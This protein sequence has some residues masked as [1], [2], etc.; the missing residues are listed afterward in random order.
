MG[1]VLASLIG[2][3][4]AAATNGLAAGCGS[5][6]SAP[7]VWYDGPQRVTLYPPSQM[8]AAD[9][10]L[11]YTVVEPVGAV[12]SAT[13]LPLTAVLVTELM[14]RKI[15]HYQFGDLHQT[16]VLLTE[17]PDTPTPVAYDV[18]ARSVTFAVR[19]RGINITTN[20]ATDTFKRLVQRL[21][22]PKDAVPA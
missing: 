8:H 5:A 13:R 1:K 3:I 11:G 7:Q 16:W 14:G 20:L 18:A 22:G 15:I 6:P 2:V 17:T 12:R 19:G 4:V 21:G 10:S 9:R